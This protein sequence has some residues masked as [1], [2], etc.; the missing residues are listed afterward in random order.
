MSWLANAIVVTPTLLL[1]LILQRVHPS[2]VS[3]YKSHKDN[4]TTRILKRS[5]EPA[6]CP[7]VT[8][9]MKIQAQLTATSSSHV[10]SQVELDQLV[11]RYIVK[12]MC[13]LS[14]GKK[15]S[16]I[17]LIEGQQLPESAL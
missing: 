16:F 11:T 5:A 4:T 17:D 7:N 13:P 2:L 6:S 8:K 1:F 10:V 15:E 3:D 12:A 14:N 9:K